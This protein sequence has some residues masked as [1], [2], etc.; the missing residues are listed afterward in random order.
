[1][2]K[3]LRR[4][5]RPTPGILELSVHRGSEEGYTPTEKEILAA[6]EGVWAVSEVTGTET[7]LLL[8]PRLP[9]LNSMFK[10]QVPSTHHTTDATWST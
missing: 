4:D 3:S 9:V 7:Q 5:L 10:G 1:M 6:Y 8:A 2:A